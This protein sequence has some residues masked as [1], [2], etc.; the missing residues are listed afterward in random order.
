M[1]K[2]YTIFLAL[3][4]VQAFAQNN[5]GIGNP[6]P[7]PSAILDLTSTTKGFLIPRMNAMQRLAI[8]TPATGLIVFDTDTGCTFFYSGAAWKN[9]CVNA[10]GSL[11]SLYFNPIGTVSAIDGGAT[12]TSVLGA[13]LNSG[14]TGT[15]QQVLILRAP[16]MHRI[17]F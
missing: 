3:L 13:W 1:K 12:K 15:I 17:L 6:N 4:S 2:I 8:A 7:D 16:L 11:D 14:N 9:M 10:G 5:V